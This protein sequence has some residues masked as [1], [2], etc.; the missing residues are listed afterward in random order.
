MEKLNQSSIEEMVDIPKMQFIP[1][2][3]LENAGLIL[4][5]T[6]RKLIKEGKLQAVK[7]GRKYF[8]PRKA[9][10]AWL[11]SNLTVKG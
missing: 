4:R 11:E 2:T 5:T 1:L 7:V 8:I 3:E 9:L 10:I 6:A